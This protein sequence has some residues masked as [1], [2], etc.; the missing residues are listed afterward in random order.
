MRHHPLANL[1]AGDEA[2]TAIEYALMGSLIAVV[3]LGAV[4]LV[5]TNTLALFSL[6]SDCVSFAVSVAPICP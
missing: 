6:V 4:G 2:V 3:I 1:V 5:G